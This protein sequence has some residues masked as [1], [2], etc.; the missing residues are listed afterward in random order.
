MSKKLVI[1]FNEKSMYIAHVKTH[2]DSTQLLQDFTIDFNSKILTDKE[3]NEVD[4]IAFKLKK[5][6]KVIN[7]TDI[8]FS[9][10]HYYISGFFTVGEQAYYFSIS[11]VRYFPEEKMLVRTAK[12]YKDFTG[13][14]NNYIKIGVGMFKNFNIR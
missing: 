12:H 7:A 11:D 2:K 3:L 14:A 6:L 10:G 8:V 13:G 5:E 9:I 1:Q 4:N